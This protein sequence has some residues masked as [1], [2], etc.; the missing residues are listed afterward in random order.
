MTVG[1]RRSRADV[2]AD[3][4][5]STD[6]SQHAPASSGNADGRGAAT[7][8]ERLAQLAERRRELMQRAGMA[9]EDESLLAGES[10]D[11][12]GPGGDSR[13]VSKSSDDF[14]LG[15]SIASDDAVGMWVPP[16]MRRTAGHNSSS[17]Y[18][19]SNF[20]LSSSTTSFSR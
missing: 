4:A 13:S 11:F 1:S 6:S 3:A 20:S 7:A 15:A 8:E 16:P 14:D 10:R 18:A 2:S 9:A 17:E 5:D 12:S 19:G